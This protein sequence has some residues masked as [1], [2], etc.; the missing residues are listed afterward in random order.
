MTADDYISALRARWPSHESGRATAE[1]LRLADEA[2]S[3]HGSSPKLWCMRGDLIQCSDSSDDGHTLL[4]ALH[5]YEAALRVDS[6][7]AEA[8]ESI[9]YYYDVI[10]IDLERALAAF[11]EAVRLGGG[12]DS[13]FG[14]ARVLAECGTARD[15][16]FSMIQTSPYRHHPKILEIRDEIQEGYYDSAS[17]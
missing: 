8:Q 11:K 4:D 16:I 15:E 5:S 2:V 17:P 14:L 1:T 12:V 6:N 3:V 9:G 13:Y 10:E 7:F